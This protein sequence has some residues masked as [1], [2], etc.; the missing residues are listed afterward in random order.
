MTWKQAKG[1]EGG[2]KGGRKGKGERDHGN[3]QRGGKEE[4]MEIKT[5]N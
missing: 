4:N 1:G 2:M 3:K 5:E